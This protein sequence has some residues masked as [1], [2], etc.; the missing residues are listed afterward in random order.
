MW[1][2][3][4]ECNLQS[5]AIRNRL[6]NIRNVGIDHRKK[7]EMKFSPWNFDKWEKNNCKRS[8]ILSWI[9][10]ARQKR[11][12]TSSYFYVIVGS[13]F[14]DRIDKI[15]I[16]AISMGQSVKKMVFYLETKL[17]LITTSESRFCLAIFSA[18][19]DKLKGFRK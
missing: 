12:I 15:V 1:R 19:D 13:F 16:R 7:N 11:L 17:K 3:S 5:N 6:T 8:P 14:S 18:F 10:E 4:K 2:E 9:K